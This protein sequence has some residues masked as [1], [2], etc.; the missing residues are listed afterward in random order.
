MLKHE[1]TL[2]G[3]RI[4]NSESDPFVQPFAV[5][6]FWISV[7]SCESV[8]QVGVAEQP[9]LAGNGFVSTYEPPNVDW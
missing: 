5:I 6:T 7:C 1:L 2:S 9:P 4:K 8:T 3:V